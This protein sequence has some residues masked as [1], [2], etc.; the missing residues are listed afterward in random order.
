[1]QYGLLTNGKQVRIYEQVKNDI[2]LVFQ[3]DG[4][5]VDTDI[6]EIKVMIGTDSLKEKSIKDYLGV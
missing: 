3:W 2:Q 4:K 1:M 5:D 6:D